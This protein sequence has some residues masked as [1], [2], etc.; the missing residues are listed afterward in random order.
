MTT[1]ADLLISPTDFKLG[2]LVVDDPSRHIEFERIIPLRE[3][4]LP[5][6]WVNT[7]DATAFENQLTGHTEVADLQRIAEHDDRVLYRATWSN[8]INGVI[9]SLR[10]T[11][12]SVL[13]GEGDHECWRFR[14]RFPDRDALQSFVDLT[15]EKGIEVTVRAVFHPHH[16]ETDRKLSETQKET[17][18]LAYE[19]GYFDVPREASLGDLSAE[20][21]ISTQA[22]SQRIRRGTANLIDRELVPR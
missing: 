6:F 8:D 3:G 7:T 21:D 5:F 20:F 13:E 16:P 14:I 2:D 15:A 11:N 10:E 18:L 1:I 12:G 9:S 22:V 17:L 19:R 4:V